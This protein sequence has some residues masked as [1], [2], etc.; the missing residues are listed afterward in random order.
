MR[1]H[2]RQEKLSPYLVRFHSFD[3]EI[4]G[5]Y[6]RDHEPMLDHND[7]LQRFQPDV[8]VHHTHGFAHRR[9]G[10]RGSSGK[11]S[12]FLVQYSISHITRS[13]ERNMQLYLLLNRMMLKYK[14]TR[15]RNLAYHVP[16]VVPLTHRLRLLETHG[17]QVCIA[18]IR[19][20]RVWRVFMR[21]FFGVFIFALPHRLY[22]LETH[23]AQVC[24]ACVLRGFGCAVLSKLCVC[25]SR[26][27]V[28][29]VHCVPIFSQPINLASF[30]L[31]TVVFRGGVRDVVR[32][33]QRRQRRATPHLPRRHSARR[34]M[35]TE[36]VRAHR[37]V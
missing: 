14:E 17:A 7:V 12:S 4:P 19:F 35:R 34:W 6:L 15:K 33:A 26:V 5:Q 27:V 21:R 1:F 37:R 2:T 22:L 28:S 29:P 18:R 36:C 11:V 32:S 25:F 16:L 24:I 20:V 30:N 8:F 3:I 31:T 10:M 23:G 9:I 13:D